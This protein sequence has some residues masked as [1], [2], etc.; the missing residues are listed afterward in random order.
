MTRVLMAVVTSMVIAVV[1]TAGAEIVR[2]PADDPWARATPARP[3][4]VP[5]DHV[6]HPEYRIEW[7]YYTGNVRDGAGRAYGYQVTFFRVGVD[8]APA[9]PSAFAVRDLYMTHVALTDASGRE[10]RFADRLN[11]AGVHWAGARTD[12]YDVWNEDWR[13]SLDD[14]GRHRI[15][16]DAGSFALDLTLS[17]GK[18]AVLQG[19]RGY[20]RKGVDPGNASHYYSLTRMPTVGSVRIDGRTI[21]VEGSSWM[22][23]EFGT[24]ALDAGTRGW[25]WFALQ[26]EDGRELMLYALRL[27]DGRPSA[28]SSGTL[29]ERDGRTTALAVSDFRLTPRRSWRSP[30]SGASYPVEWDVS[31]PRLGLTLRVSAAVDA[32][33]LRTRR[34]TNVTYWEGAVRVSGRQEQ[35]GRQSAVAGVGYLEMTGYSGAKMSDVMR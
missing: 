35:A 21:T 33:E 16:A 32:Q 3:V 20:S 24:S 14:Q 17:P 30:V 23:H 7:W 11:R 18:P 10:H 8:A 27:D 5:A 2:R 13:A 9:N 34:S 25:D 28:F 4:R 15:V 12:R 26:L 22:D 6:A 31:I 19:D 29:V 1:G